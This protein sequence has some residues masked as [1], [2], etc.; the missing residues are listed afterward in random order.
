MIP[1]RRQTEWPEDIDPINDRLISGETDDRWIFES[2]YRTHKKLLWCFLNFLAFN[3][4]RQIKIY[5][6]L[7]I[8]NESPYLEWKELLKCE[9]FFFI[10]TQKQYKIWLVKQSEFF[11]LIGKLWDFRLF[12]NTSLQAVKEL[13][14][15]GFYLDYAGMNIDDFREILELVGINPLPFF[16]DGSIFL[17]DY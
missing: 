5:T 12:T 17:R 14:E 4:F 3:R 9:E 15:R 7:G 1:E 10:L 8:R 6:P 2:M 16:E 13:K 11:A